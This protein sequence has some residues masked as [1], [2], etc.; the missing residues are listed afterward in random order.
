MVRVEWLQDEPPEAPLWA[1]LS[2]CVFSFNPE[3]SMDPGGWILP[4]PFYRCKN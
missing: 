2:E 4:T 1:R 3:T